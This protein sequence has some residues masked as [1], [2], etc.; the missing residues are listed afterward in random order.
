LLLL[1]AV[2]VS[3][4][5]G[6]TNVPLGVAVDV[7]LV[8]VGVVRAVVA[9]VRDP[10]AILIWSDDGIVRH[11]ARC[12]GNDFALVLPVHAQFVGP[13]GDLHCDVERVGTVGGID[14][15]TPHESAVYVDV[16]MLG[17]RN[18]ASVGSVAGLIG[19]DVILVCHAVP[20]AIRA[21]GRATGGVVRTLILEVGDPIP[22]CVT[23]SFGQ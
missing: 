11:R 4:L 16:D 6:I 18:R 3:V 2:A 22:I 1:V 15:L 20:V 9:I 7:G 21:A 8:R 13:R 19:T 14:V 10:V 17:G 5:V 12:G 23:G